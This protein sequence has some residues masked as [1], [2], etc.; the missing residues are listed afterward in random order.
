MYGKYK[1]KFSGTEYFSSKSNVMI[2]KKEKKN[3]AVINLNI[4][5]RKAIMR[6]AAK[7]LIAALKVLWVSMTKIADSVHTNRCTG[8]T[9]VTALYLL[10]KNGLA[11]ASEHMAGYTK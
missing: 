11:F 8:A 3:G 7:N 4:H 2:L 1:R 6:E 9:A 5:A 10:K